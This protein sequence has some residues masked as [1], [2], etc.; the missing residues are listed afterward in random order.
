MLIKRWDGGWQ[1]EVLNDLSFSLVASTSSK[2]MM[3]Q[4]DFESFPQFSSGENFKKRSEK[5]N[6]F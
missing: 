4:N 2:K 5:K 3:R 6:S 1:V